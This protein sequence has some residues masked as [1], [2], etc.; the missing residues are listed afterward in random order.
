MQAVLF[1]ALGNLF[2]WLDKQIQEDMSKAKVQIK[3]Q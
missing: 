2:Q 3:I 1:L